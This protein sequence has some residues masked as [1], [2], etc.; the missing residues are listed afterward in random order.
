MY[1]RCT[2]RRASW[3]SYHFS[4]TVGL[5][6]WSCAAGIDTVTMSGASKVTISA[7]ARLGRGQHFHTDDDWCGGDQGE[8]QDPAIARGAMVRVDMVVGHTHCRSLR[9]PT[10][11]QI[12]VWNRSTHGFSR[13]ECAKPFM[14][15]DVME[16]WLASQGMCAHQWLV[17]WR[18]C[19]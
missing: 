8:L 11:G 12:L 3:K 16:T 14:Q 4:N 9:A 7:L 18:C 5:L 1:G 10:D 17:L 2:R 6:H 15:W 19:T 13:E